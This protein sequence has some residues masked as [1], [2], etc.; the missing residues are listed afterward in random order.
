MRQLEVLTS[1]SCH[2]VGFGHK[3][4]II[5]LRLHLRAENRGVTCRGTSPAA[6]PLAG[7]GDFQQW[8]LFRRSYVRPSL[9][10]QEI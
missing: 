2:P 7:V 8:S 10:P 4:S 5:Y 6:T 9:S 1:R 3:E